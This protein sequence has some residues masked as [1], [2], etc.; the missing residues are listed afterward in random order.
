MPLP[1]RPYEP[2]VFVVIAPYLPYLGIA[3]FIFL[4]M[5]GILHARLNILH[6]TAENLQD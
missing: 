3:L 1:V 4:Q 6:R 2:T 5:I